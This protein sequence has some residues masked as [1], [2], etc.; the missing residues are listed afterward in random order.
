MKKKLTRSRDEKWLGGVCG[1]IAAYTGIETNIIRLVVTIGT[2]LGAGS[3]VL[4]YIAA[5]ILIPSEP[6]H[7]TWGP[8]TDGPTTPPGPGQPSA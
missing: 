5:W 6:R 1:G 3:L 8:A 7:T 2:V 4:A